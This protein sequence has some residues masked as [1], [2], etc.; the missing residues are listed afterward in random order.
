MRRLKSSKYEIVRA[1][2]SAILSELVASIDKLS[3]IKELFGLCQPIKS[4]PDRT[5]T[6][7]LS[8]SGKISRCV[9][10]ESCPNKATVSAASP[11]FQSEALAQ[12]PFLKA[13]RQEAC[14]YTPVWLMR[15]A[16]RY[17]KEY[18]DIRTKVSFL[19]LCRTPE[20]AC[21][22][23]VHAQ[24]TLSADAAIIFADI[25]LPLDALGVG[26]DYNKGGPVITCPFS[27]A[28]DLDRFSA[29]DVLESLAYVF[30][31]IRLTRQS[32][33]SNIPLI[34]FAGAPFT[35]ASYLIEGGSSRN[36]EKTKSLMYR[37]PELW[38]ALLDRLVSLS[39]LY[40]DGQVQAGAQALQIFDSWAGT[41]AP[42]DYSEFVLPHSRRLID[43][44]N[45]VVPV[46]H[47]GTGTAGLLALMK[48]AGGTVLGLD[49]RVD[50]VETWRLLADVSVQGNL[51]PC[52]LLSE[53]EF[54]KFKVH[55]LLAR[56][57]GK[58]GH[59][60]NLGHGVLPQTPPD[61]VRYLVE[62]VHTYRG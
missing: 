37:E 40:L 19:E 53:R 44:L 39:I 12:S 59:I 38:H 42:A 2:A 55:E 61:N 5:G 18:R 34:G 11:D 41:L 25:L 6:L 23:T 46:I 36:F 13:C 20:L 51:D 45:K 1:V 26:L 15:Q 14:A 8:E 31:S 48:Q 54:I 7:S 29:F 57:D 9:V 47:F 10:E 30:D 62:L 17:M 60:F 28:A 16:G 32:L 24:E 3:F 4:V 27:K 56:V 33:K 52:V 35:L 49:W 21:Q 50:L 22:V 58:P 43:S